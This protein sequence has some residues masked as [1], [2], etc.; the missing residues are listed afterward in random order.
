M[1]F[2]LSPESKWNK[3]AKETAETLEPLGFAVI[4]FEGD[5]LSNQ[6][7]VTENSSEAL[8]C[9]TGDYTTIFVSDDLSI[10]GMETVYHEAFHALRR[11][12]RGVKPRNKIV[13]A[14][15]N[16]VDF[17]SEAFEKYVSTIAKFY[18]Y[19]V[20]KIRPMSFWIKVVQKKTYGTVNILIVE[21]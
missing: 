3:N 2:K 10:D 13:K 12:N 7:D 16:G 9:G 6:K 15:S 14:I 20:K 19:S 8:T 18:S 17:E 1:A 5:F 4:V 21:Q 11:V